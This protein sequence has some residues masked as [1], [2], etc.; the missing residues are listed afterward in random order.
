[1]S[2]Q[3]LNETEKTESVF[4]GHIPLARGAIPRYRERLFRIQGPV[5]EL[6]NQPSISRARQESPIPIEAVARSIARTQR[7]TGEIP[8]CR[9]EKTDP[10]DHVEAAM[11][12]AAA[13]RPEDARRAYEWLASVQLPDGAWYA[14]YRDGTPS[15][16]RR[17]PNMTAY[18]AV[19]VFHQYLATGDRRFLGRM[20]GTVA[21]AIDF[22]LGLQAPGGEIHWSLDPDGRVDPMAL[23]TGSSS[24][25]MSLKCALAIADALGKR[26]T[27]WE[28]GRRRLA[29]AISE[30]PFLFNMTKS[31]YSMDWFYPILSGA[32]CG[33]AARRRLARSWRKFVIRGH[34][35][36]CVS[37]QP[38]V[39]VAETAE[40][41]LTLSA[42][43]DRTLSE[44]V[45]SWI[46]DKRYEDGA[47][48]CGHTYPDMVI[49][50]EERMTW[51]DGVV[52]LAADALYGLTPAGDLFS[53]RRWNHP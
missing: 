22:A 28:R 43:G 36:R 14:E 42:M 41:C 30:K 33:D 29:R 32:V 31:R 50:P 24:I 18:V 4:N 26:R 35:V 27:R 49:W 7:E 9:G 47:Y 52:L 40:L 38:W 11:G 13:G 8:W 39:T 21:G 20:W 45:F 23:L 51:T 2:R 34:G 6:K 15:D 53:H 37:D 46:C 25:H 1:M 5:T 17:D 19:G 48:W 16:R 12:L 3:A 44:I 10:W